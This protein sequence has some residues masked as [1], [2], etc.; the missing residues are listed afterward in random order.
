MGA[1][2]FLLQKLLEL[3]FL[4][5]DAGNMP[6]AAR[7]LHPLHGPDAALGRLL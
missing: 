7:S 3:R 5:L 1:T 2:I 4:L 6:A